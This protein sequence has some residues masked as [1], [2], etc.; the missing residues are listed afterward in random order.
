MTAPAA[1]QD[2]GPGRALDM[3]TG[4]CLCEIT[5]YGRHSFALA[6]LVNEFF[7]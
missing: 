3:I 4:P 1:C 2:P 7:A 5:R 6:L